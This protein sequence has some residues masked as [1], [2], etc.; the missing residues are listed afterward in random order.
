MARTGGNV[1]QMDAL[2]PNIRALTGVLSLAGSQGAEY[3]DVLKDMYNA[4]GTV[5]KGAAIMGDTMAAKLKIAENSVSNLGV[6]IT[7]KLL[8]GLG[9]AAQAATTLINWSDKMNAAFAESSKKVTESAKTYGEYR[10]NVLL[11]ARAADLLT[12]AQMHAI[13]TGEDANGQRLTAAQID[14]FLAKKIDL[15]TEAEWNHTRALLKA[16]DALLKTPD[17]MARVSAAMKD[18]TGA[19]QAAEFQAIKTADQL[20]EEAKAYDKL[21]E[22]L[23][24]TTIEQS[25][26]VESFKD[27]KPIDLARQTIA[28]LEGEMEAN[29]QNRENYAAQIR[30]IKSEFGLITPAM[31]AGAQ[32]FSVLES[33][34]MSGAVSTESYKTALEKVKQAALDGS[35]AAGELGLKTGEAAAFM[36]ASTGKAAGASDSIVKTASE[37][38]IE[39]IDQMEGGVIETENKM[40]GAISTA[41]LSISNSFTAASALAKA[42]TAE[43]QA[44]WDSI[45]K[46]VNTNYSILVNGAALAGVTGSA[47]QG[48]SSAPTAPPTVPNTGG[49]PRPPKDNN[50]IAGGRNVAGVTVS[51]PITINGATSPQA[52]ATAISRYLGS[53]LDQRMRTQ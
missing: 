43:I 31:E 5:E 1:E 42:T 14:E 4:Q 10:K 28:D 49:T 24:N 21:Q 11:T 2:I 7:E 46:N 27:I 47:P 29:P 16:N 38:K 9:D 35:V 36:E 15:L 40:G 45:P 19:D 34:W 53:L 22:S 37:K 6:A 30:A 18:K 3:A 8:P 17:Y 20:K 51:A 23:V 13:V 48:G 44:Y 52:T 33:L 32:A 41:M 50:P 26:F 39:L 12:E 25:N